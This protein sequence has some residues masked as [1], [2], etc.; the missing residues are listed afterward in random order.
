MHRKTE[1]SDDAS[2]SII[3]RSRLISVLTFGSLWEFFTK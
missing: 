1:R 2:M 3:N